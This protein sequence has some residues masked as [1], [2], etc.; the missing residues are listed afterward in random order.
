[1]GFE[2]PPAF[3]KN[4]KGWATRR[5]A[6]PSKIA[7]G[8]A[9]STVVR[10]SGPAPDDEQSSGMTESQIDRIRKTEEAIRELVQLAAQIRQEAD[11]LPMEDPGVRDELLE[12]AEGFEIQALD[13][14]NALREWREDIH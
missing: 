6:H 12:T 1:M 4:A 10:R 13:L 8:E 7:K 5:G 2:N 3:A 11:K 9:A 14:R